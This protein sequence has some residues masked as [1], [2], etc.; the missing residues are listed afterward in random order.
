MGLFWG[1]QDFRYSD[2]FV[3]LHTW[4]FNLFAEA[5]EL[6]QVFLEIWTATYFDTKVSFYLEITKILNTIAVKS[7]LR[8]RETHNALQLPV[9]FFFFLFFCQRYPEYRRI[10]NKKLFYRHQRA[11]TIHGFTDPFPVLKIYKCY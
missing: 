8:L 11:N 2:Q 4:F 7:L 1:S 9:F 5:K 6:K 3:I 10:R